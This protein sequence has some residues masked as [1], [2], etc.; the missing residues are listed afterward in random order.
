[1]RICWGRPDQGRFGRS[2]VCPRFKPVDFPCRQS[3]C[4][5]DPLFAKELS[6]AT[7]TVTLHRVLRAP[8][9]R[10]YNASWTATRSR[11]GCRP[12]AIA[13][14]A[15]GSAAGGTSNP[16][17]LGRSTVPN[18]ITSRVLRDRVSAARVAANTWSWCRKLK[19]RGL[20]SA[21]REPLARAASGPRAATRPHRRRR[22]AA[23]GR[24]P[25]LQHPD[26]VG[27]REVGVR[28]LVL[29]VQGVRKIRDAVAGDLA[30]QRAAVFAGIGVGAVVQRLAGRA[31][32]PVEPGAAEDLARGA[33]ARAPASSRPVTKVSP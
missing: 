24:A 16:G 28:Q 32:Q 3:S 17:R 21:K 19:I 2:R 10:V 12:M 13:Q 23:S 8:A 11:D 26:A 25:D 27:G 7:G 33:G 31:G 14:V 30:H 15:G 29:A 4:Q 1:M 22:P 6:M 20:D 18:R 9:E 5:Y